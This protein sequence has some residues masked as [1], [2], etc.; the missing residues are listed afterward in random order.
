[1]WDEVPASILNLISSID[2]IPAYVKNLRWDLLAWNKAASAV[3]GYHTEPDFERNI[4]KRIFLSEPVRA[5]QP[6]WPT[7]AR[8]V[9]SAFRVD[10]A[11]AVGSAMGDEVNTLVN[12]LCE[13]S[14]AFAELW[15]TPEVVPFGH[16]TKA[17]LLP[18]RRSIQL[19][20]SALVIDSHPELGVV[21]YRPVTQSDAHLLEELIGA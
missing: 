8:F 7:V 5:A 19:E 18:G 3:F 1:M 14:V 11:R 13:A 6:D 15:R 12:E 10:A 9:V 17:L 2:G 20:Y 16:G 21:F 4:L